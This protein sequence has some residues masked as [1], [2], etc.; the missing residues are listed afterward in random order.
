M[1]NVLISVADP[2]KLCAYNELVVET[3]KDDKK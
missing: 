3:S 1:S 2:E